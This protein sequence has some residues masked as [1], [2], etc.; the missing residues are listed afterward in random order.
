MVYYRIMNIGPCYTVG[1][2]L[3]TLYAQSHMVIRNSRSLPPL[4][5]SPLATAGLLSESYLAGLCV[6]HVLDSTSE[7]CDL[8]L[9]SWSTPLAMVIARLIPVAA[10]CGIS[11]FCGW[12]MLHWMHRSFFI[13]SSVSAHWGCLHV[14]AIL[15]CCSEH[16][17]PGIILDQRFVWRH[18]RETHFWTIWYL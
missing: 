6:W 13:H 16:R 4:L 14:L 12:V 18:A 15:L 11:F 1:P 8:V 9:V 2:C 10:S 5:P 3:S 17:D 7:W